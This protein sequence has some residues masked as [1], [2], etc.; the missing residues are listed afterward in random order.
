M[1]V[2]AAGLADVAVA[3]AHPAVLLR[4]DQHLLDQAAVVLLHERPLGQLTA[5]PLEP[6][7]Q[8][9]PHALQLAQA[10]DARPA[11]GAHAPVEPGT[12]VGAAE[13]VRELRLELR[14]LVEQRAAC[15]ALVN[16]R[17]RYS[18]RPQCQYLSYGL[19]LP[20]GF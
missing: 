10:E 9:V 5:V 2:V 7:R 11:A 15:G 16:S 12:R 1:P 17:P 3:D 19:T 6:V 20:F 13:E 8:L 4:L 18:R 14:D